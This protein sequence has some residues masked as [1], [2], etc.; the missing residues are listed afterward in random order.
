M[1]TDS[2]QLFLNEIGRS[3]LLTAREE[4]ELARRIERGDLEAKHTMV[5][6]NLRLVVSIAKR[7]RDQGLPFLDLIQEG[8]VGLVRA[9]EKFDYRRGFKFSTY[10][11]WW[12]RQ[13][14]SRALA[15]QGRTIRIPVQ[16]LE[17]L[18]KI[19]LA[20]RRLETELGREPSVVEVAAASA[21]EPEEVEW[22][23][24]VAQAP[25]SLERP[26]GEGED[27]AFADLIA[28]EQAECPHERAVMVLGEVAL[29]EALGTLPVRQRR[30]IELRYGLGG[31]RP[32]TLDEVARVF[33]VTRERIRQIELQAMRKLQR[34]ADA[35]MGLG[36]ANG[37]SAGS[38]PSAVRSD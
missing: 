15:D 37:R 6:S 16:M 30:V 28:D 33:D 25:I 24:R 10:A 18:N 20:E 32:R 1:T 5:V 26:V 29:R 7:Y 2:L 31:E 4:L 35:E 9:T 17:R 8:T 21:L 14:I 3:R 13:A 27:A 22:L 11:V 34:F 12:I 38:A 23:R 19:R 36:P